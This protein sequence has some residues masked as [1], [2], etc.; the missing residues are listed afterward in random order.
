MHLENFGTFFWL[1]ASALLKLVLAEHGSEE[2]RSVFQ[3]AGC[4]YTTSLCFGEALGVLKVKRFY[5]KANKRFLRLCIS[6]Q[7][8]TFEGTLEAIALSLKKHRF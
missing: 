8:T 5:R 7:Q 2:L 6:G 1:D 4:V 3:A